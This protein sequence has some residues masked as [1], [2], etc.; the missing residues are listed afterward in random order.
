[1]DGLLSIAIILAASCPSRELSGSQ[2]SCT[3]NK[4]YY[5]IYICYTYIT[6]IPIIFCDR[7]GK[8]QEIT[9]LDLTTSKY[10]NF[11]TVKKI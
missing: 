2:L 4:I 10:Y 5:H 9:I 7:K 8:I 6:S 11:E 3:L 1:M